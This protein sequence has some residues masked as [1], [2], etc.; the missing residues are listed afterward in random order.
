[1]YISLLL[2]LCVA[3]GF[4]FIREQDKIIEEDDKRLKEDRTYVYCH[5]EE[6]KKTDDKVK[7]L[8]KQDRN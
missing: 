7:R 3:I 6:I 1:M 4:Y 2:I 5:I 8:F